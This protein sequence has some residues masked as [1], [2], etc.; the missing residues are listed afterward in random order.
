[1]IKSVLT[2][3]MI[4]VVCTATAIAQTTATQALMQKLSHYKTFQARFKQVT[5]TANNKLVAKSRGRCY[6]Q[7]PNQFRWET[8]SPNK[9]VIIG[10]G[11]FL[12]VYDVDLMQATKRPV[13]PKKWS[14]AKLLMG[15]AGSLSQFFNV[16]QQQQAGKQVFTLTKKHADQTFSQV[17]FIFNKNK[18]VKLLV[19]NSLG[20]LATFDFYQARYNK[21]IAARLFQFKAKPGVDVINVKQ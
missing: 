9:Q 5:V 12:W 1:M 3:C 8:S 17:D 14:P 10:N 6:T 16:K 11:H 7:R 20:Q 13:S 2:G 15:D 21:K 19:T 4:L 18:L